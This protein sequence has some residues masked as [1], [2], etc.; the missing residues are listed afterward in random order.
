MSPL[1]FERCCSDFAL[2]VNLRDEDLLPFAT[3]RLALVVAPYGHRLVDAHERWLHA[4]EIRLAAVVT[5]IPH[6]QTLAG[7]EYQRRQGEAA[8]E[9]WRGECARFAECV[10]G[11]GEDVAPSTLRSAEMAS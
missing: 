4:Y 7:R 8:Y 5:P 11:V 1:D 6:E 9:A 3:H 10:S 2:A